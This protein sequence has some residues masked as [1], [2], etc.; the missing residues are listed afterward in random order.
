[1]K[2]LLMISL[3]VLVI[4]ACD[5]LE[6]T[7]PVVTEAPEEVAIAT[8]EVAETKDFASLIQQ[9]EDLYAQT[10]AA[11]HAWSVNLD[12]LKD[13]RQAAEEGDMDKAVANAEEA[14]ELS[15]LALI[16]AQAEKDLWQE[17]VPK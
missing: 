14:I 12:S 9:A 10:K 15:R 13:A 17:R 7:D 11:N 8:A 2:R 5:K 3:A 4:T 1:M 6:A 16:Q